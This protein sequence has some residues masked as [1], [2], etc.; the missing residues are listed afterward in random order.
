VKLGIIPAVAALAV[1][2]VTVTIAQTQAPAPPKNLRIIA[3]GS[4]V[5][6]PAP[7]PTP[8]PPTPCATPQATGKSAH[9]YFEAI[10][11]R[12]EHLCNFSLRSQAQLNSLVADPSSTYFTYDPASD[13]YAGKQDAAKFYVGTPAQTGRTSASIPT[14]QQVRIP[15]QPLSGGSL[16]ITWDWY[17]GPE[18]LTQRGA[19]NHYKA[20]HVILGGHALWTLMH[21]PAWADSGDI[22]K[23]WDSFVTPSGP[24]NG[25]VSR[26]PWTPCGEGCPDQRKGSGEQ[27]GIKANT[28]MRYWLEIKMFQPPSAFVEWTRV[29]GQTLQPNPSDPQGR[30][31]MASLWFADETRAPQRLLYRIPVGWLD[32]WNPAISRFDF[33]MNTSQST[34]FIGPWTGYGRNVVILQDYQ[35]PASRP[36]ADT[37]IFQRPVR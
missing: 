32:T 34:G 8:P 22:G 23:V 31:H 25:L 7:T 10:T 17:W 20:F 4:P 28:W 30:W 36:E 1:A 37:V 13:T 12:A 14:K 27:V 24:P 2:F 3:G 15:I 6:A 16:M 5:P 26:E 21:S 29:T 33:E 18:F 11:S 35:L 19:M 9:A